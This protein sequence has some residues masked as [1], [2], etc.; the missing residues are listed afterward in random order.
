MSKSPRKAPARPKAAAVR[1]A[2]RTP[3]AGPQRYIADIYHEI[4]VPGGGVKIANPGDYVVT[5]G[6]K[7]SVHPPERFA[8][9]YPDLA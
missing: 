8:E 3:D 5:E 9:A 6:G 1:Q 7:V 4:E 2:K